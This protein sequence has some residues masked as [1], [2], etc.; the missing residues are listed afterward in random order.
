MK[1]SGLIHNNQGTDF[2]IIAGLFLLIACQNHPSGKLFLRDRDPW[3]MR[4]VLDQQARMVT[5]ALHQDAYAAYNTENCALYKVW[6]GGVHWDGAPFNNVK[7]IQPKSWGDDYLGRPIDE[8]PWRIQRNGQRVVVEPQFRGYFLEDNQVTFRYE[9]VLS[10]GSIVTIYEQPE[11][12]PLDG[13]KVGYQRIFRTEDVPDN[14]YI[15]NGSLQLPR[16]GEATFVDYFEPFPQ[17]NDGPTRQLSESSTQ[18]WLDRSG[19]NTCH[20]IDLR[21]IGPS[22]REIAGRYDQNA[23]IIAE[24][25]KKVKN[26]GSGVWGDVPMLAHPD[27]PESA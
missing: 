23:E 25:V 3:V 18:N 7:T 17:L 10:N 4:S 14:L 22:Y 26:G 9:L 8:K 20:E 13:G 27:L 1:I 2:L 15:W 24:L 16:N 5:L 19:C 21:T 11:F 6:R 12:L